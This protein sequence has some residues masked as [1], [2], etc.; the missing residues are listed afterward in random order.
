MKLRRKKILKAIEGIGTEA[1]RAN[2][3]E[4]LKRQ[5]YIEVN[6][7]QIRVTDKGC[8]LCENIKDV[9]ISSAEMTAKWEGYLKKNP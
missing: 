2:I 6:A 1:T 7:S 3:L 9:E 4:T 5:E 8:V